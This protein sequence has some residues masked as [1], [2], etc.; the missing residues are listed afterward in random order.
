MS[1][2]SKGTKGE[3]DLDHC[4]WAS[5]WACVRVSGSGSMQFPLPDILAGNSKRRLAIECKTTKAKSKYFSNEEI[6]NLVKFAEIFGAEP[7][8]AVKFDRKCW[9]FI[10]ATDIKK[11]GLMYS[12]ACESTESTKLGFEDLVSSPN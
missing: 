1:K 9:Q 3:R 5:G 4:F 10:K 7:W 6:D 11:K 2:K 12:V 8:V